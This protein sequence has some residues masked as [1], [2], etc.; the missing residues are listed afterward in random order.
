MRPEP[1]HHMISWI[2]EQ[3]GSYDTVQLNAIKVD[4][5]FILIIC[6]IT[7]YYYVTYLRYQVQVEPKLDM[8][9]WLL[10]LHSFIEHR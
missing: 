8:V 9:S 1:K 4:W 7:L 5:M 3:K 2:V 10:K 6:Q